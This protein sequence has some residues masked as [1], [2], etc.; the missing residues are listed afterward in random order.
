MWYIWHTPLD[1]Y[2]LVDL[3]SRDSLFNSEKPLLN[4]LFD[5]FKV[6]LFLFTGYLI[7]L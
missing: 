1:Q 5:L 7:F 6:I 2:I 3:F 4:Y